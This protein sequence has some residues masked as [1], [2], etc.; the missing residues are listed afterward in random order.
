MPPG[1][2]VVKAAS[3][4]VEPVPA[5]CVILPAV[6]GAWISTLRAS[7]IVNEFNG[8]PLPTAAMIVMSLAGPAVKTRSLLPSIVLEMT[9]SPLPS[10][11]MVAGAVNVMGVWNMIS[12][13]FVFKNPERWTVPAPDSV[14]G[15]AMSVEEP[16]LSV[17][18][19]AWE[20]VTGPAAVVIRE[21]LNV[22]A[23]PVR[24]IPCT[25]FVSRVPVRVVVPAPAA[26]VME[27]A[28]KEVME[29]FCAL[30]N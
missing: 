13:L 27:A 16:G 29:M 12:A 7:V 26:C 28:F 19:P 20:I 23:F 30:V 25:A 15:P 14:K 17:K 10:L 6:I 8:V 4:S 21:P 2:D 1:P 22:K 9:M 3:I 24:E 18:S 5:V 11:L